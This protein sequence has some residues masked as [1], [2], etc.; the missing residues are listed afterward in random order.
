MF[1]HRQAICDGPL[2]PTS[3]FEWCGKLEFVTC[4]AR[5]LHI[6]GTRKRR[7]EEGGT[8]C[9]KWDYFLFTLA[10]ACPRKEIPKAQMHCIFK[11]QSILTLSCFWMGHSPVHCPLETH[12]MDYLC[13]WVSTKAMG[14]AN[15]GV[16]YLF[17]NYNW[18]F[19]LQDSLKHNFLS[20]LKRIKSCNSTKN[21][22]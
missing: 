17:V 16:K 22:T 14:R 3:N 11:K 10:N 6:G 4:I 5:K 12:G 21:C 18:T 8:T 19:R 20:L 7:C 2:Y 1:C 9:Y 13:N 15:R